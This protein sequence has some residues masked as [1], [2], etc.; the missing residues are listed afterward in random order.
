VPE[1]FR[2]GGWYRSCEMIRNFTVFAKSSLKKPFAHHFPLFENLREIR[3]KSGANSLFSK[4]CSPE[5]PGF[6]DVRVIF[7]SRNAIHRRHR[8]PQI[9]HR[10]REPRHR[11]DQ[12]DA[13]SREPA[14]ER[15]VQAGRHYGEQYGDGHRIRHRYR[16]RD[17]IPKGR[18]RS[19]RNSSSRSFRSSPTSASP[20]R[21]GP[22][23]R[24][25]SSLPR[26]KPVSREPTPRNSPSFRD[27]KR[28]TPSRSTRRSL[29][30]PWN[31]RCFSTAEGNVRP[32]LA[33]IHLKINADGSAAFA[34]TDS[35]R[36]S[37]FVLKKA[38]AGAADS[39][40]III[41]AKTATE[42]SRILTED[43][44]V[45]LFVSENQPPRDVRQHQAFLPPSQRAF[46]RLP[47][48]LS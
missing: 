48:L 29:R 33:G 11:F 44:K 43:G 45:E 14:F 35:F 41:P 30:R 46:P 8:R 39:P 4:R 5:K 13:H 38:V 40:G 15:P 28:K 12:Y 7:P 10:S 3:L 6:S 27:S 20:F 42:L 37:E 16:G 23:E 21:S 32:T 2:L 26:A 1:G 17:R 18:T 24:S 36:L 19:L 22:A 47:E 34:S 31:T 9:R 25:N